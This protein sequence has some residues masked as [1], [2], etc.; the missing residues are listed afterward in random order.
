[1]LKIFYREEMVND[2]YSMELSVSKSPL[3]PKLVVEN[4]LKGPLKS[5]I[6]VSSFE[7]LGKD[8]FTIAHD[9]TYVDN[10]FN[11]VYPDC[12]TNGIP[13]SPKLIDTIRY[14]NGSLYSAMRDAVSNRNSFTLSPTSGFHHAKPFRGVGFCTFSG[15]VIASVKLFNEYNLRGAYFDLDGHF[16]NSIEDSKVFQPLTEKAIS[17]N[18][19]IYGSNNYY[20]EDLKMKLDVVHQS[21]INKQTDYVVWCHGA[22]SHEEDDF[23]GQEKVSTEYWLKCSELFYSTVKSWREEGLDVPVIA[24]L[25]GGYRKDNYDFV[26]D[27]HTKDIEIGIQTLVL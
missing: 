13:W 19:N 9:S 12:A 25:F 26:I 15:Q 27:L 3:K 16:G 10:V 24:S 11:G 22:D 8:D 5:L 18:M 2:D 14:T 23:V 4:L 6:E 1:M 7:P 21:I 20:L 17:Y